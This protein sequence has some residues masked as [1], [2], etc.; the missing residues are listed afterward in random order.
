MSRRNPTIDK[1]HLGEMSDRAW[2]RLAGKANDLLRA[3][4]IHNADGASKI[5][6]VE[7]DAKRP[8]TPIGAAAFY[9]ASHRPERTVLSF[10]LAVD[11]RF[12][13]RGIGRVLI[14]GLMRVIDEYARF[15]AQAHIRVDVNV[16]NDRVLEMLRKRGFTIT[17]LGGV[18]EWHAVKDIR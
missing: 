17:Y 13:G 15:Y 7:V 10:D 11:E 6:L 9:V 14:D 8:K 3:N 5:Q 1:G 12:R 4:G 18:Q 2:D 16:V